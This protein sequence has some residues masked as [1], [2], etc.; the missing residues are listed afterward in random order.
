MATSATC[1]IAYLANSV[2]PA[3]TFLP[4][5]VSP[6]KLEIQF[7]KHEKCC[8]KS[9][10]LFMVFLYCTIY[11]EQE[12]KYWLSLENLLPNSNVHLHNMYKLGTIHIGHLNSRGRE[13]R[14]KFVKNY[15]DF[16][17]HWG[18]CKKQKQITKVLLCG[19]SFTVYNHDC[20]FLVSALEKVIC[21]PSFLSS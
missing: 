19:W 5:L 4:A 2:H 15:L 10:R 11:R 9:E 18:Q 14:S 16:L 20:C 21:I 6:H 7:S 13:E 8:Q 12:K 1:K 3:A 17:G